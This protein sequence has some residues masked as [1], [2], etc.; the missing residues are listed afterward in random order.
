[1]QLAPPFHASYQILATPAAAR[2]CEKAT[3]AASALLAT[4]ECQRTVS[5]HPRAIPFAA[6]AQTYRYLTR[7][8][9]KEMQLVR[10]H[11][12]FLEAIAALC[13]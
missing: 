10:K 3:A 12:K 6:R 8:A 7:R 4:I 11:R 5:G 2:Q 9:H 13:P 1:M